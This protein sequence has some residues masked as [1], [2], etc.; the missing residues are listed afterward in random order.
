MNS[1]RVFP[2]WGKCGMWT[3]KV[4]L[5]QRVAVLDHRDPPPTV[6]LRL[7]TPGAGTDLRRRADAAHVGGD[8]GRDD[9]HREV[10]IP[11]RR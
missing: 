7:L 3:S 1:E 5:G 10:V 11:G 9:R 2:S 6:P 4:A 8:G